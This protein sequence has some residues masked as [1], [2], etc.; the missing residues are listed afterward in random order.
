MWPAARAGRRK[1]CLRGELTRGFTAV[2]SA[3]LFVCLYTTCLR[4]RTCLPVLWPTFC[5][6]DPMAEGSCRPGPP[7]SPAAVPAAPEVRPAG[8]PGR[9]GQC[10]PGACGPQ[11]LCLQPAQQRCRA[12]WLGS[13]CRQG[14]SEA[15]TP[16]CW[17]AGAG[18]EAWCNCWPVSAFSYRWAASD[19]SKWALTLFLA[20]DSGGLSGGAWAGIGVAIAAA[21][22]AAAGLATLIAVRRRR[23]RTASSSSGAASR[24]RAGS[25]GAGSGGTPA[26]GEGAAEASDASLLQLRRQQASAGVGSLLRVRFGGLEGLE[27]GSLIGRGAGGGGVGVGW[28]GGGDGGGCD[29]QAFVAR[30]A[31]RGS[32]LT[33]MLNNAGGRADGQQLQ[34]VF[35]STSAACHE[36]NPSPPHRQNQ[37]CR[38]PHAGAFGRV[39]AG[40]LRGV[41]VA[42]KASRGQARGGRACGAAVPCACGPAHPALPKSFSFWNRTPACYPLPLHSSTC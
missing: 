17:R 6:M 5:I 12:R 18:Q 26:E 30:A 33:A 27:I 34:C 20:G 11:H 23:A 1:L 8:L 32:N 22:A 42:V 37:P 16:C 38:T 3:A 35:A 14:A 29:A 40:R 25:S 4:C 15:S 10:Q 7:A 28:G 36:F 41:P 9:R 21:V 19:G 31:A 24:L 39:Y 2:H 13:G